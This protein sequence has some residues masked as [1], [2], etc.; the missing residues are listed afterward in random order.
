MIFEWMSD[1][2][3]WVG[4]ATLVVLEIVL[5]IDNLVFIA[6]L[7][8][9]LPPEQRAAAR[10]IGLILA[11]LMRLVLLASI[12]WVVTLTQPLF[13][14]FDHPFSGRDL[15]LLF[16]GVF[17]L[18]KGTMELHERIEGKQILKEENPVHAAFWMVVVQIVV[19]DAVFSLDSVITAVGMV[20]DLSVM[21]IAVTIAIGIM[22]LAARPLMEFVNKH[23]TVVILCLGFLMMIGFSL[24][25]E[26][27]GFHIPKG[28]LYA[29]IGFSV[30]V[31][32]VNQTMRRNQEK[33][34]TTTDLRYRTASAVLRMLGGKNDGQNKEAEDVL[35]TQ[36]YAKEVFDED[37]GVYHSV[38]VQGVLGLSERPVKSV[39]TPRPELEW[40]DLDSDPE[41]LKQRLMAMTHSRLIIAR[42]ELDNI[43]GIVLTHKVL[44]EYIETGSIDFT[45]HIREPLIVHENAQ[46]LMVM[47]QLRQAPLQMAIVLNEYGSI[48][49]IATPIDVL[50]AIAGEFPDEDELE[51]AAASLEDG[52]MLLEGSTDIRH[53]SLLLGKDLVDESEEYSTLSGYILFHLGRLPENG[54]M[55]EADGHRFEVVTMDG[56]K[57]EKV[58]IIAKDKTS[59]K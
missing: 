6:I 26:G 51:A 39:M 13:H 11:L 32:M 9:K 27:F 59:E 55:I 56:H 15:I 5:G 36:A 58:R 42:G 16:G 29:A 57:I 1:P 33:L 49:G 53:V 37:N 23:P 4:L 34:V 35:A 40:L 17:L 54:E 30:L 48:E 41:E 7:A 43:E 2:S 24:V 12:A 3:A 14:V 46:V 8:E 28:Y 45:K 52:S 21:M 31:E 25:V 22:L 44:N 18:F 20:K 38:L 50:E 19:L 10:R 47:E